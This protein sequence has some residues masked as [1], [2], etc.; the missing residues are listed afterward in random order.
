MFRKLGIA[1][2]VAGAAMGLALSAAPAHAIDDEKEKVHDHPP[3]YIINQQEQTQ[4]A[5]SESN[6]VSE[7]TNANENANAATLDVSLGL[8]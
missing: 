3:I 7:N 8:L 1:G 2:L 4:E 6:A 5:N